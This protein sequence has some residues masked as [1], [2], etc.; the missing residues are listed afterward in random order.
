MEADVRVSEMQLLSQEKDQKT[1]NLKITAAEHCSALEL[2]H[3][4]E[5]QSSYNPNIPD[6]SLYLA[7]LQC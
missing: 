2:Y 7:H 4:I 5:Q 3:C 6:P 1:Y